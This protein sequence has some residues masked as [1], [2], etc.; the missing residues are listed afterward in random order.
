MSLVA[1]AAVAVVVA[2]EVMVEEVMVEEVMVGDGG[3]GD[4]GGC[5]AHLVG[6]AE[7]THVD[8][9]RLRHLLLAAVLLDP[10]NAEAQD[11]RGGVDIA[12]LW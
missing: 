5:G 6:H 10:L 9:E 8:F 1:R 12:R 4:G 3:G 11:A 2:V 7:A